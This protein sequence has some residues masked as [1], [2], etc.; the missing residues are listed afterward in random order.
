ME[1]EI[2]EF[3]EA[4]VAIE[5]KPSD[6]NYSLFK[7]IFKRSNYF[8]LNKKFLI[9]KIS[10]S[11]KPFFGVGKPYI[12]LLHLLD[13][14]FLVL[15]VNSREGWVYSKAEINAN[16]EKAIWRLNDKD[17]NYKINSYTLKGKNQFT[18]PAEFLRR[19]ELTPQN[20]T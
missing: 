1:R 3:V 16:I 13:N 10:R 11:E 18:S 19:P 5:P 2:K 17:N 12:E 6:E 9:V 20:Q 15:L 14:Y 8:K 4:V 7:S